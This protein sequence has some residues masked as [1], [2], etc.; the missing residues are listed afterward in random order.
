MAEA[1]PQVQA[2]LVHAHHAHVQA[3]AQAEADRQAVHRHVTD[4]HT[5]D[6]GHTVDMHSHNSMVH[7]HGQQHHS[8]G[9]DLNAHNA[10][11][12]NPHGH[13]M[14]LVHQHGHHGQMHSDGH[15]HGH[16]M[17]HGEGGDVDGEDVGGDEDMEDEDGNRDDSHLVEGGG[18]ALGATQLTLSYQGEVYVFDTVPPEKVQAVLLVLGGREIPAGMAGGNASPGYKDQY[19]KFHNELPAR[20]NLPQRLASLTRFREKRKERC[21]DKKIRYTVRKEVAQRM[22][23]KRGQFAPSRPAGEE[24]TGNFN[25]SGQASSGDG[26]AINPNTPEAICVHCGTGERSTPMMRRGP[27]GPR[28]LCNACGLMWA[29]KGILRDLTKSPGPVM[30]QQSHMLNQQQILIQT[31]RDEDNMVG[32]EESLERGVIGLETE[33]SNPE[34]KGVQPDQAEPEINVPEMTV[35]QIMPNQVQ[36]QEILPPEDPNLTQVG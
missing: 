24:N 28:S 32:L 12:N 21:Y 20:M 14:G 22:Q 10:H 23:R 27:Q 33:V 26:S 5:V 9:H 15:G 18:R 1:D 17:D 13:P 36:Q 30:P 8:H 25:G 11:N 7:G 2:Q 35:P 29:N 6:P 34:L 16:G 3:M 19:N 31:P 4:D